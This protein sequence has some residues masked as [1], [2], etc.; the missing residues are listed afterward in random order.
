MCR[1]DIKIKGGIELL[2]QNEGKMSGFTGSLHALLQATNFRKYYKYFIHDLQHHSVPPV[3]SKQYILRVYFPMKESPNSIQ[4]TATIGRNQPP[5]IS[6]NPLVPS[7]R[8][9]SSLES[10]I[11]IIRSRESSTSRISYTST[12]DIYRAY[13]T[14]SPYTRNGT[15]TFPR[16]RPCSQP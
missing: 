4:P 12:N 11:C 2:I 15:L 16:W 1:T 13:C 9:Q 6:P 5:T 3:N 10:S 14:F 8:Q 7:T